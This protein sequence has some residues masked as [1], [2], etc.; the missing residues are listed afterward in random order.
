MIR[1]GL[2]AATTPGGTSRVTTLP[3]PITHPSPIVIPGKHDRAAAD[4]HAVADADRPGVFEPGG[5][6][7]P[8]ERMGRRVELHRRAHLQIVADLDRRA[9]EKHAV[10]VDEGALSR[11]GYCS[12]NRRK[13]A[14]G[15]RPR[16]RPRRTARAAVSIG[17]R[18]VRASRVVSHQQKLRAAPLDDQL[19]VAALYS[20][21]ASIF[22]FSLIGIARPLYAA[23]VSVLTVCY[24]IA[25]SGSCECIHARPTGQYGAEM[26]A[27]PLWRDPGQ[28]AIYDQAG[29]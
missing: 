12:R 7:P 10:V 11:C 13:T 1:A 22:S 27:S 26:A 5:A 4:P 19:R 23:S 3:A 18:I 14:A 28:E 15:C 17:P 29:K 9:V 25:L 16:R 24:A 20:S 21:P 2:P 8:I 6:G